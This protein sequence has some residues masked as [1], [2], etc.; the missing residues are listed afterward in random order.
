MVQTVKEFL[1]DSYQLISA[2]SPTVPLKNG[3]IQKG[4]KIMNRLLSSFSGT[5]L[6]ITVPKEVTTSV[7]Y[8]QAFV[9]FASSGADINEGRLANMSDSWLEY[10]GVTYPLTIYQ[11]HEFFSQYKF[12]PLKGLPLYAI[13]FDEINSTRVQLYPAPSQG[14]EFFAYGK[15]ELP[16]F[17]SASDMD[18]L[19][20]YFQ[21][22]FQFAVAKDLAF[23]NG[24]AS[25]WTQDLENI[26]TIARDDM[27]SISNMNL[28][29][30][31]PVG[32]MLNGAA[33]VKAG[34]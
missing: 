5:G 22:F 14:Y 29:I 13:V 23:Y 8:G 33:R 27:E 28:N 18:A 31:E 1:D 24:R 21:R 30:V 17:T 34:V 10:Q 19:P 32:N 15:F 12:S 25:A 11:D 3:Y 26:L 6:M 16:P 9:T 2:S 20:E 4:I 7:V